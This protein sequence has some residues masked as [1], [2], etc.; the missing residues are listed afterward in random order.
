MTVV[1]RAVAL[2]S[3]V[4]VG[5]W[6][7]HALTSTGPAPETPA[8]DGRTLTTLDRARVDGRL[9]LVSART[10]QG[11]AHVARRLARAHRAAA[12]SLP[13]RAVE[14][15]DLT[16]VADAY[17]ALERAAAAG[18]SSD[19]RRAR[20]SVEAAEARLAR[21]VSSAARPASQ[22]EP[23]RRNPALMIVV[24]L[25]LLGVALALTR[26]RRPPAAPATRN[27]APPP[28]GWLAVDPVGRWDAPPVD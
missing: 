8:R 21:V 4:V 28:S 6:A 18:S 13:R 20:A 25:A 22:H 2:V 12:E 14:A 27:P 1:A 26:R 24:L 3:A 5:M 17:T 23:A 15:D 16:L 11:Q 7:G 9:A 10:R 19:F